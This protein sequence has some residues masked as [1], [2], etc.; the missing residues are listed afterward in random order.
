MGVSTVYREKSR[1]GHLLERVHHSRK[2]TDEVQTDVLVV[3]V[4]NDAPLQV[5]S[6][7]S[8]ASSAVHV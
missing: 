8:F 4:S 7:R 2:I 1:S 5:L 3:L 6:V